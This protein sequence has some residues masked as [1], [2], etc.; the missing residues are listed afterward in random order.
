MTNTTFLMVPSTG[1]T[2]YLST[3]YFTHR[4]EANFSIFNASYNP[5]TMRKAPMSSI[6]SLST[7]DDLIY[8]IKEGLLRSI[9]VDIDIT[10]SHVADLIIHLIAP[11]GKNRTLH[12]RSG[13]SD[14]QL[15][16][17]YP[18]TLTPSESL[19]EFI[20]TQINGNWILRVFDAAS[21]DSGTLNSWKLNLEYD[22]TSTSATTRTSRPNTSQND[23]DDER[24]YTRD[25]AKL[26][27]LLK[28][29]VKSKINL[30]SLANVSMPSS[31]NIN[32]YNLFYKNKVQISN[33]DD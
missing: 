12:N 9:N 5:F 8:V 30:P 29:V 33:K 15:K 23:E 22:T 26:F 7:V 19:N 17:N 25:E 13:G 3:P 21:G 31:I 32:F 16:G 1:R 4:T 2:P 27:E 18:R 28:E 6:Y 20:G 24:E 10:H 11:N 14:N